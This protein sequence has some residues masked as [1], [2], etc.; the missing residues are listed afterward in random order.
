[1]SE[2]QALEFEDWLKKEKKKRKI[3]DG[4]KIVYIREFVEII[5]SATQANED[6][7]VNQPSLFKS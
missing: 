4:T 5:N 6:I 1:M 2:E 3:S 7:E